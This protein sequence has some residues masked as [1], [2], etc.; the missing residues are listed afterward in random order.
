MGDNYYIHFGSGQGGRPPGGILRGLLSLIIP[1]LGQLVSGYFWRAIGHFLL[2]LFLWGILLGWLI[3]I[4]SAWE[5][6]RLEPR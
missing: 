2:A 6:S 3:H 5:A 4:Y 1:G